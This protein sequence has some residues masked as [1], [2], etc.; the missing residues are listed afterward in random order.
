MKN[1]V[2]SIS[3]KLLI[4]VYSFIFI[5]A[6]NNFI[7]A[8]RTF[9]TNNNGIFNLFIF[10]LISI[11][12]FVT[13]FYLNYYF[14]KKYNF[15]IKRRYQ[16]IIIIFYS[17]IMVLFIIYHLQD[18]FVFHP[19]YSVK[20]ERINVNNRYEPLNIDNKYYGFG[21]IDQSKVSPTILYFGGNGESTAVN[22]YLFNKEDIFKYYQG[23][24][25]I[26]FDY[27]SYG[28]SK[29]KA[30]EE[31]IYLMVDRIMEYLET[32][33]Y[34]D[35]NNIVVMGFSLGTGVASYTASKYN[36]NKLVLLAPYN[37]FSDTMNQFIPIFYSLI[38]YSLS[39]QL[40]SSKLSKKL[41]ES[42]N[43][44]NLKTFVLVEEG[45]NEIPYSPNALFIINNFINDY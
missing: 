16:S 34:V 36:V 11:I 17:L 13:L 1:K 29:G 8:K 41:I 25:F 32:N 30:N 9:S 20:A 37:N 26:S 45:H 10:I 7:S 28:L 24:N 40:V 12:I 44:N 43:N 6:L 19:N 33:P 39:D 18:Q 31:N 14:N 3:V 21:K 15:K 22:F 35:M 38:I 27:P 42:S 5:A 2:V 23:F 4:M